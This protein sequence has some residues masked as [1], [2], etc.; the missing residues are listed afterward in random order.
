MKPG[1]RG[2]ADRVI[3]Q[4]PAGHKPLEDFADFFHSDLILSKFLASRMVFSSNLNFSGTDASRMAFRH[5]GLPRSVAASAAISKIEP[6]TGTYRHQFLSLT[7][8]PSLI[9]LPPPHATSP[10]L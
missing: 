5:A 9:L 2:T 6:Q 8:I 7:S 10:K 4:R 1:S 3:L